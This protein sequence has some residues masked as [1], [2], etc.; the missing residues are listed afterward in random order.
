[1]RTGGV[2]LGQSLGKSSWISKVPETAVVVVELDQTLSVVCVEL[3]LVVEETELLSQSSATA[4]RSLLDT[5]R[6]YTYQFESVR[7]CV[8]L[9]KSVFSAEGPI[10][11]VIT[12]KGSYST[13]TL[14]LVMVGIVACTSGAS[15]GK[16]L[17]TTTSGASMDGRVL[18]LSTDGLMMDGRWARSHG[19]MG[20][21]CRSDDRRDIGDEHEAS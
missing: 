21:C 20:D 12:S 6:S 9:I 19:K 10:Y 11:R 2:T 15:A 7:E 16:M 14:V 17:V 1:M 4:L 13:T 3:L 18:T 5:D 8:G